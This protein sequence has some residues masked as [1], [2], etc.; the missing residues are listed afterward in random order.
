MLWRG[1]EGVSRMEN[2]RSQVAMDF[3]F[4]KGVENVGR[5]KR[6]FLVCRS[7]LS[8]CSL[9]ALHD[10]GSATSK[11]TLISSV[12]SSSSLVSLLVVP[13]KVLNGL[14][15]LKVAEGLVVPLFN[16]PRSESSAF[17]CL[18]QFLRQQTRSLQ[19]DSA[20]LHIPACSRYLSRLC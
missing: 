12:V 2:P 19:N 15:V 11:A 8:G 7:L 17:F 13:P 18:K 20:Q 4:S 3:K 10:S 1:T 9:V 5:V 14:C 6:S 16:L